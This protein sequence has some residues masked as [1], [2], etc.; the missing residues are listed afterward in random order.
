LIGNA[1]PPVL[2]A[3]LIEPALRAHGLGPAEMSP[4]RSAPKLRTVKRSP[5]SRRKRQPRRAGVPAA[6]SAQALRRM[7]TTR[8]RDTAPELALR[9]ELH[10]S[11]LRYR[12]D[13]R[14]DGMRGRADIVF[15]GPRVVVY[16]DGCFWHGCP[17]HAT[18]PK[19]NR[20]WWATKLAANRRRDAETDDWLR[21][22]GWTIL[23]FW[24]HE[25]PSV[26]AA[27]VC[28]V[29]EQARSTS[30][31]HTE[32]RLQLIAGGHHTRWSD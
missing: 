29:I 2:A 32:S 25:K 19:E 1:V 9:A 20:R 13:C 28:A 16:V 27:Y 23:R 24:E 12:V 21:R 14:L 7:Q 30:N 10:R 11:G 8:Q 26:A 4:H 15:L 6:S 5:Q 17:Q 31:G 18:A 3:A 22:A